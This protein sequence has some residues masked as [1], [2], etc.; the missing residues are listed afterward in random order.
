MVKFLHSNGATKF[1]EAIHPFLDHIQTSGVAETN[2]SIIAKRDAGNDRYIRLAQE[3]VGEILR[4]QS[5]L[6]DVDENIKRTLRADDADMFHGSSIAPVRKVG[7]GKPIRLRI[8]STVS[9]VI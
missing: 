8:R 2:S 5:E 4:C 7:F 9:S 6:T 3:P 1:L